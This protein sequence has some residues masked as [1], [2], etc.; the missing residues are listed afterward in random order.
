MGLQYCIKGGAVVQLKK[1]LTIFIAHSLALIWTLI[2]IAPGGIVG[3]IS[4]HRIVV[5][6][7]VTR[8]DQYNWSMHQIHTWADRLD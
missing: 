6:D 1:N 8:K 2:E 5:L 4:W 7:I 3:S